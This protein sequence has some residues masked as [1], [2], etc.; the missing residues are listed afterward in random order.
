MSALA[1]TG[2]LEYGYGFDVTDNI[3]MEGRVYAT[4]V[5]DSPLLWPHD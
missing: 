5:S 4:C 1:F 2:H 3:Y